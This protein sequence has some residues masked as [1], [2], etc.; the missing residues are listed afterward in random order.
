MFKSKL[1]AA[2]STSTSVIAEKDRIDLTIRIPARSKVKVE[3]LSGAVDVVG[4][5]EAAEVQTDT[6]TIHA[7]GPLEAL[8]FKFSGRPASHVT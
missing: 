5:V 6:G 7:A 1:K 4:N 2:R 8:Q 3:S